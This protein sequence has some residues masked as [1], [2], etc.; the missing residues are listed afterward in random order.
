MILSR[1]RVD[2][3]RIFSL[4][5]ELISKPHACR[6]WWRLSWLRILL[7]HAA[8]GAEPARGCLPHGYEELAAPSPLRAALQHRNSNPSHSVL[9]TYSNIATRVPAD[10]RIL[11]KCTPE[12]TRLP[13]P[14]RPSHRSSLSP[15]GKCFPRASVTT[16]SPVT[17]HTSA[18]SV[19][20]E[21]RWRGGFA[22]PA[23]ARFLNSCCAPSSHDRRGPFPNPAPHRRAFWPARDPLTRR[24]DVG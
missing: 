12:A 2:N 13:S 20:A 7:R 8:L 4:L 23:V 16:R 14:F 3:Q 5:C 1:C 17:D 11:R 24:R 15:T 18:S 19:P 6:G 10:D 21:V 9:R 22:I